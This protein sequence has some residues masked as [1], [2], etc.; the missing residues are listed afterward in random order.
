M[1][2]I[3]MVVVMLGLFVSGC[4][5]TNGTLKENEAIRE[6]RV[7]GC[8]DGWRSQKEAKFLVDKTNAILEPQI[9]VRLNVI[10]WQSAKFPPHTAG[11]LLNELE[12]HLEKRK[13]E[14]DIGI[15][16]TT[17]RFDEWIFHNVLGLYEG[18]TDPFYNRYVVIYVMN[19]MVLA[20]EIHHCFLGDNVFAINTKVIPFLP[21]IGNAGFLMPSQIKKAKANKW[22]NF[23]ES[24]IELSV[25]RSYKHDWVQIHFPHWKE[26]YPEQ[27]GP[28]SEY[29]KNHENQELR[30]GKK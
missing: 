6:L 5:M 11:N 20:H 12:Y 26:K 8:L 21:S 30:I 18:V 28:G 27:Y 14:F 22:R 16:F 9:G 10:E 15:L 2:K 7:I 3:L 29:A 24:P 4:A 19:P 25:D 17:Y 23:S 1:K 13:D